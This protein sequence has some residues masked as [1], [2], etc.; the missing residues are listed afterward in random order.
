MTLPVR[1]LAAFIAAPLLISLVLAALSPINSEAWTPPP[2]PALAG[3]YAVNDRL[4]GAD[5]LA[6]GK[7]RGPEDVDVDAQGRVYAGLDDGRIVRVLADGTVEDFADTGGRPLGLAFDAGG[8]LIVADA[9]KGLLS[10]SSGGQISVLATEA[11]GL[12]F[13]FTDDVDIGPNGI[14]YFTDASSKWHQPDYELD[15]LETRP[16]GRLLAH[17]PET[18]ETRVLLDGLYFA[19]GVAVSPAGD[20]LLVNETWRY[21]VLRYWLLGPRAGQHEVFID[22]L[23]GFPDG[24]SS[25]GKGVYWL[26]LPSPRKADLDFIHRFP[27]LKEIAAALP[28]PLR[29]KAIR[30]GFVL[31]LDENAQVVANLHDITGDHLREI[32]SV[33]Q[34]G[35]NVYFGSLSN[36][37][38]GRMGAADALAKQASAANP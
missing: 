27:L 21:R 26:A 35:E 15:L 8:R 7:I 3:V 37:R 36:D 10:I 2:A 14:I 18:G 33:Q 17:H 11:N 38:I 5:L 22:N 24:I 31:A 1:L 34:V 12:P 13:G 16:W 19:N 4:A 20:Y 30:Y 9:W 29:P 32:T 23:P 25:N 28:Q 6:R